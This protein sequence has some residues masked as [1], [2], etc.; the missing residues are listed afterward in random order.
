MH[1]LQEIL[2]SVEG[3]DIRSYSGRGMNGRECLGVV[4]P[5]INSFLKVVLVATLDEDF[6]KSLGQDIIDAIDNMK[7]D[8]MGRDT[9]VYFPDIPCYGH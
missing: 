2:E 5:D 8:S 3:Q 9:I 4:V 7:E 1:I 6:D